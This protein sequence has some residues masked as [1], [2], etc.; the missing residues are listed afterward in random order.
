[1]DTMAQRYTL[2]T[3]FITVYGPDDDK[4]RPAVVLFHGCGGLRPHVHTYAQAAALT[5]VRAYVVDSFAARGWDRNF[6]VSLICTGVV[7][8]G[9]ERSGDV[10]SV[11]WGLRESRLVDMDNI[12]LVGYSHGGWS[13]MDLMTEP[14]TQSGEAKLTDPDAS[15]ANVRGLFLVYPYINFPARSNGNAWLRHP[16]VFAVLAEKD[17]LTP[18]KHSR[19]VFDAV[20]AAGSEVT[21]LSLNATH[22]FDEEDN[23]GGVMRYSADAMRQSMAAMLTFMEATLALPTQA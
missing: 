6:A 14:L 19:K 11:L 21:V 15:L 7:M 3:P 9:Y 10:L 5:G 18:I 23:K 4:V 20:K 17:H 12:M 13:I 8:Q 1:M 2:L 16:K 22:A